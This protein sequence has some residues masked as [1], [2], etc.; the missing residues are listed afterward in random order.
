MFRHQRLLRG[1]VSGH[2]RQ[3]RLHPGPRGER[4]MDLPHSRADGQGIPRLLAEEHQ[5]Y[6]PE[7]RL[8]ERPEEASVGL[9]QSGDLGHARCVRPRRGGGIFPS[10]FLFMHAKALHERMFVRQQLVISG[11]GRGWCGDVASIGSVCM[12]L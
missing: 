2:Y 4:D 6:Q 7:F 1:D 12:T 8:I 11:K 9:P 3:A 5:Q 10:R